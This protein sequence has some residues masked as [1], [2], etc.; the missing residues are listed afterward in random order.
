MGTV[1]YVLVVLAIAIAFMILIPVIQNVNEQKDKVL[2][3]FCEID[4]S[5]LKVLALRTEIFISSLSRE[6]GSDDVESNAEMEDALPAED[7]ED[8]YSLISGS[9]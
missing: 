9:L 2:S 1:L 7:E 5:V 6:E 3:L 4:N 8:E